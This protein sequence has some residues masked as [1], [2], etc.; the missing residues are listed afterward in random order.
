M[1]PRIEM[2]RLAIE[3]VQEFVDVDFW[4]MVGITENR[5]VPDGRVIAHLEDQPEIEVVLLGL[6]GR[7]RLPEGR[8]RVGFYIAQPAVPREKLVGKILVA[9]VEEAP[10]ASPATREEPVRDGRPVLTTVK[11]TTADGVVRMKLTPEGVRLLLT[12]PGSLDVLSGI[13]L[14][15][16][17]LSLSDRS[18]LTVRAAIDILHENG[19]SRDIPH[20]DLFQRVL[21]GVRADASFFSGLDGETFYL[22]SGT[23]IDQRLGAMDL[24]PKLDQL[25]QRPHDGR[26]PRVEV[27]HVAPVV[28]AGLLT[29]HCLV[30]SEDRL[31]WAAFDP[32]ATA[33]TREEA[34]LAGPGCQHIVSA[35]FDGSGVRVL[36]SPTHV[37]RLVVTRS[38][39]VW[40]RGP[41]LE[42]V[43][44]DGS[45]R[46]SLGSFSG[47]SGLAA[48]DED[49]LLSLHD[50]QRWVIARLDTAR[51]ELAV[52]VRCDEPIRLLAVV[53]D[54]LVWCEGAQRSIV[55]MARPDGTFQREMFRTDEVVRALS[56]WRRELAVVTE[57]SLYRISFKTGKPTA[58]AR[59]EDRMPVGAAVGAAEALFV[60]HEP[61]RV[62]SAGNV[63]LAVGAMIER[64]DARGEV[65]HALSPDRMGEDAETGPSRIE[66][67]IVRDGALYF[68]ETGEYGRSKG[69]IRR[70]PL[71]APPARS[72][73]RR[74]RAEPTPGEERHMERRRAFASRLGALFQ[75][76]P[77]APRLL[78]LGWEGTLLEGVIDPP[79]GGRLWYV[80]TSGLTNPCG[81]PGGQACPTGAGYELI[82]LCD[83]HPLWGPA[84]LESLVERQLARLGPRDVACAVERD[85]GFLVRDGALAET[86]PAYLL[87]PGSLVVPAAHRFS[88]GEVHLLCVLAITG[89]EL[90]HATS[91]GP[92]ALAGALRAAGLGEICLPGRRSVLL[93]S[94]MREV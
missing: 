79:D 23:D 36:A 67:L 46:R 53:L 60:T 17:A 83:A 32:E 24:K 63:P 76:A 69:S 80:A 31:F 56:A 51:R 28:V 26:S 2:M 18:G 61:F 37:D 49:V 39:V 45:D 90:T 93:R 1:K 71:D 33:L 6:Q 19:L 88:F 40:S 35:R 86:S 91:E 82:L 15:A 78:A 87:V 7:E 47:L 62:F 92:A 59:S 58:T 74:G 75:G 77:V 42:V 84:V 55:K 41:N 48:W 66:G 29:P 85:G 10:E 64:I 5:R 4:Y 22:D 11:T 8:F 65:I 73:R 34:Y 89:D 16:I 27:P 30:G 44:Q 94:E 25:L 57:G 38:A 70:L 81:G 3:S 72:E 43:R 13:E 9:E 54:R 14:F 21:E 12:A 20:I 50:G 68:A 52:I